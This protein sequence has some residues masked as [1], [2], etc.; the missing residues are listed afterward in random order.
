MKWFDVDQN[1]HD[2]YVMRAGMATASQFD[3]IITPKMGKLSGQADD[4]A[5]MC[6]AELLLGKP[7]D[8]NFSVYATEWGHA[9]E[10]EAIALYKLLTGLDVQRGGFFANDRLTLGASPDARIFEGDKLVGLAEIKCPEN[11]ARHVEFLLME[12]MNPKYIP[13][14]QGQLF[15][16]GCEWV[17]WFSYYPELPPVRVRTYRDP[18]YQ[19][20]LYDALTGF[21]LLVEAKLQKLFDAG[22][23]EEIPRKQISQNV[24]L[25]ADDGGERFLNAG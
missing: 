11:P 1:S 9:Y 7:I 10:A 5:N 25:P 17:D 15:V 19:A 14:V 2:W 24:E 3:K 21:E 20:A 23:I 12:E 22:K 8:R 16:S 6:V 4:Y 18:E 13:Q